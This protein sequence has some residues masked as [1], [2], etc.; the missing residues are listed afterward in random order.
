MMSNRWHSIIGLFGLAVGISLNAQAQDC[1]LVKA[2]VADNEVLK[3]TFAV[4]RIVDS[5]VLLFRG[6]LT[7]DADGAPRAYH[8][9]DPQN[10]KCPSVGKGLDCPANGGLPGPGYAIAHDDK[11]QL[12]IQQADDPEPGFYVSVTALSHGD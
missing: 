11:N 4:Y 7:L 10:G 1:R 2:G 6:G 8:P 5:K 12:A 3:K 9:D